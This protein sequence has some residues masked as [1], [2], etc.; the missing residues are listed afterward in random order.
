MEPITA[1]VVAA[2]ARLAEPAIKDAY[3]ILKEA[4]KRRFPNVA[5]ATD[6]LERA[7]ESEERLLALAEEIRKSSPHH[8]QV[9]RAKLDALHALLKSDE[10]NP[11]PIQQFVSGEGHIFTATGDVNIGKFPKPD[12]PPGA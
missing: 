1:A 8:D 7:P 12:A 9:I 4:F 3:N 6:G 10:K 2:L 5:D 11:P